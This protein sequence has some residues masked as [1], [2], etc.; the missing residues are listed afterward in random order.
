MIT[1]GWAYLFIAFGTM[2]KIKWMAIVGTSYV[3][4]LWLPFTPEKLITIP[5]SVFLHKILFLRKEK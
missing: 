2:L 4:F 3:A 1:N 5:L